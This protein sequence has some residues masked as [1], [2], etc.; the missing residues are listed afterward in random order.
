MEHLATS[1]WHNPSLTKKAKS[2]RDDIKKGIL[3]HGIV[4]HEKYGL[5]YAYEVGGLGNA[6]LV[7]YANIPNLMSL[8]YLRYE[9]DPA[10]Y[11]NTKKFI[12]LSTDNPTFHEG[13][14]PITGD[15]GGI[16]RRMIASAFKIISGPWPLPCRE[17]KASHGGHGVDARNF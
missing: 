14:N 13:T 12:L 1:L 3:E 7:N 10:I 15:I 6:L 8:T 4:K 16:D 2:L 5:I 9:Y 17:D 11:E